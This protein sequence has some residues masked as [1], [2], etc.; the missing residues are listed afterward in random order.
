MQTQCTAA[1]AGG[2]LWMRA[3]VAGSGNDL[4][5][6]TWSAADLERERAA[7][8]RLLKRLGLRE[9][10]RIANALPGALATPGSL[11]LGDVV[12][13]L[14]G[15]DVPVG[16]I[17]ND[18]AATQAWTLIDLVEPE[19]LVLDRTSATHLFAAGPA[20]QRTWWKGVLWLR[21]DGDDGSVPSVPAALGTD[22]RQKRF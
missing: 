13:D 3:G 7:G 6:L 8:V 18:N 4:L 12:Q 20:A 19:V 17:E 16:A 14:G 9:G 1:F 22:G 21:P 15:L 5:V 2:F 10:A 11:L